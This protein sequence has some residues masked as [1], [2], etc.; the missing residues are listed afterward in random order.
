ML[1]LFV[2][3]EMFR[4]GVANSKVENLTLVQDDLAA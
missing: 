3:V 2:S 1:E 4:G